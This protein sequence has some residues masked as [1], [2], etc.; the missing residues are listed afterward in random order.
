M[1]KVF[2]LK[3]FLITALLIYFLLG[4][5]LSHSQQSTEQFI[6]IGQS[7]RISNI[8]S[9]TGNVV[10]VDQSVK[11]LVVDSSRGLITVKVTASTR[12]WLDR[13][14]AKKTNI[15]ANYDDIEIGVLVEVKQASEDATIAD[16]VKI[17][18][19]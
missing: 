11:T 2:L 9:V 16:W 10:A 1:T 14:K 6:P 13:S 5:S 4:A 15:E 18:S 17:Q 12:L 19:G 7:P 8:V 3:I